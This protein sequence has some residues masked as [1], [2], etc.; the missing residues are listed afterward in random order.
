[1]MASIYS[2]H[3]SIDWAV[4]YMALRG[5]GVAECYISVLDLTPP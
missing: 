4:E 1:M 2:A 3:V 5:I